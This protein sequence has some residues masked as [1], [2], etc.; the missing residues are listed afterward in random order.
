MNNETQVIVDDLAEST[1]LISVVQLP[2]ITEQLHTVKA[3]IEAAVSEA[4][5]MECTEESLQAVKKKRTELRKSFEDLEQ[6]RK[7]AKDQ[8]MAPYNAFDAVYK[9]CVTNVFEPGD[10]A[11]KKAIDN[12][13]DGIKAEKSKKAEA[14][15]NEYAAS[16]SIDFLTWDMV[17][18]SVTKSVSQKKLQEQAKACLDR[19]RSE[20][21]M[22][23]T[24]EYADEVLAEYKANGCNVSSAVVT[25]K[26]RHEAVERERQRREAIAQDQKRRATAAAEKRAIMEAAANDYD[27]VSECAPVEE[28]LA[29]PDIAPIQ[30]P[31][32]INDPAE[33]EQEY[34]LTFKVWGTMSRL[35]D[36]KSFLVE[37]GYR[38]E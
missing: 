4:L 9:E 1:E 37:G 38:F 10:L 27:P 33:K 36:L 20:L 29:A 23:S 13:E 8:V 32:R 2:I 30:E 15:F 26:K 5:S 16:L 12:I 18:I 34:M 28:P 17:G 14:Y 31:E 6:R 11:L 19:V 24:Q 22:I 7:M 3:Q 35:K 21:D 25:V